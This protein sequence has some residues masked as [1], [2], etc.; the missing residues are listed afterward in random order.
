[1]PDKG[2]SKEIDSIAALLRLDFAS[3]FMQ[4]GP[5]RNKKQSNLM[6]HEL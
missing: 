5:L 4:A 2:N 6:V 1:M 3:G